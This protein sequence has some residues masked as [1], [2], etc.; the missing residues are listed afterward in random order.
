MWRQF[1][2]QRDELVTFSITTEFYRGGAG[3]FSTDYMNVDLVCQKEDLVDIS[4]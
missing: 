3:F 2:G 1:I 4:H